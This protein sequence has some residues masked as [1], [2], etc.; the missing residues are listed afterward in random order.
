MRFAIWNKTNP[1]GAGAVSS[2]ETRSSAGAVDGEILWTGQ[3][4][5]DGWDRAHAVAIDA[6]GNILVAGYVGGALPGQTHAGDLDA[7][8]RKYSP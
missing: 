8:L 2:Q 4:G 3:F 1:Q 6:S 5:T 7:F